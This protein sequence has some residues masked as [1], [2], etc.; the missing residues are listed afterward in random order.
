VLP[1]LAAAA[2]LDLYDW[3]GVAPIVV[4]ARVLGVHGRFTEVAATS[5]LRG[6][7]PAGTRLLVDVG[8]ANAARSESQ[9]P[10]RLE[11]GDEYLLLLQAAPARGR[12]RDRQPSYTLTRGIDG[13][14][15]LPGEGRP[16]LMEAV[17]QLVAVQDRHDDLEV[18]NALRAMLEDPNPI[19]VQT[20][21]RH[22]LKYHRGE[23]ELLP[24]LQILL[25]HPRPDVRAGSAELIG[26]ILERSGAD[27]FAGPAELLSTLYGCARRDPDSTVRAAATA[28]LRGVEGHGSDEVLREI[29]RED[30]DQ[31]VRYE[32]E[33]ILLDRRLRAKDATR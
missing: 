30:S 16:A 31:S 2:P 18:W 1:S 26:Q 3:L 27:S 12:N 5:V 20:A 10:L 29:A 14:R 6:E 22:H 23:R 8:E 25:D 17:R 28:S 11:E 32:A 15:P 4:E 7:M 19:L 21:L 13:A 9:R 24:S 33:K